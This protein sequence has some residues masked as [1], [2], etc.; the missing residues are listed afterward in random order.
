MTCSEPQRAIASLLESKAAVRAGT[1]SAAAGPILP[2]ASAAC[3]RTDRSTS[4]RTAVR[5]GTASAAAGPILPRASAAC[6]RT[7]RST[8]PRT[9]VNDSPLEGDGFEP[10]VP[11]RKSWFLL[12]K[13]NC[14]TERGQPK[15]VVFYAVQMVR[16]HLPPVRNCCEPNFFVNIRRFGPV[17]I[18]SADCGGSRPRI[19]DNVARSRFP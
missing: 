13:A 17:P 4:P 8:S 3:C 19:R 12:R 9:A 6:R 14:G 18:A 2:R 7:D 16:I 5:A 10:S 11:A 15:R 1:A